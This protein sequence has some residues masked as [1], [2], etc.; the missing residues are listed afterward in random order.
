[1]WSKEQYRRSLD[2]DLQESLSRT[3]FLGT[4]HYSNTRYLDSNDNHQLRSSSR[5]WK[6]QAT[7][8]SVSSSSPGYQHQSC[9]PLWT[10]WLFQLLHRSST[11]PTRLVGMI[12]PPCPN[13]INVRRSKWT[14]WCHLPIYQSPTST[15]R[16][17]TWSR[18]YGRRQKLSVLCRLPPG[19]RLRLSCYL[20]WTR[21]I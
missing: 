2:D 20:R 12:R 16:A 15:A 21:G 7:H 8:R 17:I 5:T 11:V 10:P 18:T 3:I 9:N 13:R 14:H 4:S 1:M 6:N 19:L